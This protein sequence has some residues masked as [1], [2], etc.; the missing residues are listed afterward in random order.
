VLRACRSRTPPSLK[1]TNVGL[2]FGSQLLGQASSEPADEGHQRGVGPSLVPNELVAVEERGSM[3]KIQMVVVGLVGVAAVG[4]AGC[5]TSPRPPAAGLSAGTHAGAKTL[6][7][8]PAGGTANVQTPG[9]TD[10]PGVPSGTP[11]TFSVKVRSVTCGPKAA[12]QVRTV[13]AYAR[14]VYGPGGT[15]SALQ[16][17]PPGQ[18]WC[19][20]V[21]D[22][23]NTSTDTAAWTFID[24]VHPNSLDVG[25]R[26]Y[27]ADVP[28][29][30]VSSDFSLWADDHGEPISAQGG[31]SPGASGLD[32]SVFAIPAGAKPT[33]IW[34]DQTDMVGADAGIK[35]AL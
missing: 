16:S 4:V 23:T 27:R 30:Q 3:V 6:A 19:L 15:D 2:E 17:A 18:Q 7:S 11:F 13:E 29:Q 5:G 22:V 20:V 8:I 34:I 26:A 35:L 10:Q 31:L 21:L 32:Y 24:T 33:S 12:A 14:Q 25:Q 28:A 1:A 9:P